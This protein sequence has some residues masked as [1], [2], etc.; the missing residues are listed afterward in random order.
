MRE[1]T[2]LEVDANAVAADIGVHGLDALGQRPLRSRSLQGERPVAA[3]ER[4]DR[5]A[6][7][8]PELHLARDGSSSHGSNGP[9]LEHQVIAEF[10]RLTHATMVAFCHQLSSSSSATEIDPLDRGDQ[11]DARP[12]MSNAPAAHDG[13]MIDALRGELEKRFSSAARTRCVLTT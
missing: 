7:P 5:L 12:R 10:H 13:H 3:K 8:C 2:G 11:R 1:R 9:R 4:L 6:E